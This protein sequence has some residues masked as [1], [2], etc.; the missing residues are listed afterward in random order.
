MSIL[1]RLLLVEASGAWIEPAY[2]VNIIGQNCEELWS[3]SKL[4]NVE[5]RLRFLFFLD[6]WVTIS[7]VYKSGSVERK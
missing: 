2:E 5:S 4:T 7:M 3:P 6:L 1:G